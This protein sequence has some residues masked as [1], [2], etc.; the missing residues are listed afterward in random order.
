MRYTSM[1]LEVLFRTLCETAEFHSL[2][3][4]GMFLTEE[5]GDRRERWKKAVDEN[6][7]EWGFS[8]DDRIILKGFLGELGKSDGEGERHFCEEYGALIEGQLLQAQES[9][10][11]YGRMYITLGVCGGVAA[12][13]LLL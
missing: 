12:A 3:F 10:R 13:L 5:M 4:G 1:P 7:K 9:W 2:P 6:G 8:V 11:V